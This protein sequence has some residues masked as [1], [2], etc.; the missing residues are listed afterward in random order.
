[1]NQ[2]S[3]KARLGVMLLDFVLPL[4]VVSYPLDTIGHI[5]FLKPLHLQEVSTYLLLFI[6]LNKDFYHG[7]SIGKRAMGFQVLSNVDGEP[8][9]PVQCLIRNM[10]LVIWPVEAL[11][12]AF[13]RKRRIGDLLARTVLVRRDKVRARTILADI[14][15]TKPTPQVI[16]T[17]VLALVYI[18]VIRLGLS[19]LIPTL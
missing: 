9:S 7:R 15:S 16:L 3:A 4:I 12:S 18:A 19:E 6:Y 8:A 13:S 10:T 14:K 11:F 5:E 2:T 17:A 1:M